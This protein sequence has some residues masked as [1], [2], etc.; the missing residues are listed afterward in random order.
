VY[1]TKNLD[2]TLNKEILKT[3]NES[4]YKNIKNN[5]DNLK[6]IQVGITLANENGEYPEDVSTWQF[7]FKFDLE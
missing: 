2:S 6:V 3:E 1:T 4:N 7:N 5:V